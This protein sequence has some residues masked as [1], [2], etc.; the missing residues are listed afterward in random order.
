MTVINFKAH[1]G[2]GTRDKKEK[3]F[4]LNKRGNTLSKGRTPLQ[5]VKK[6]K[7]KIKIKQTNYYKRK[8]YILDPMPWLDEGLFGDQ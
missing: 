1:K 3:Y 8:S 4:S 5:K 7:I 6:I 2:K